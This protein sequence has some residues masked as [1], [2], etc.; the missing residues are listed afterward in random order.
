MFT[1][2]TGI[3]A[4]YKPIPYEEWLAGHPR[5]DMPVAVRQRMCLSRRL[6]YNLEANGGARFK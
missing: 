2:V 4:V 5:K 6:P 1:K 3:R